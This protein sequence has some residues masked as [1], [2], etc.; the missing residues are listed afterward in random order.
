MTDGRKSPSAM[1]SPVPLPPLPRRHRLRIRPHHN[2]TN[3]TFYALRFIGLAGFIG[4]RHN[5]GPMPTKHRAFCDSVM[6]PRR[7]MSHVA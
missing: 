7:S 2:G 3:G 5:K 1:E 4:S 6:V